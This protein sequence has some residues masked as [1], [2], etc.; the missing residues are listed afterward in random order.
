[1][2]AHTEPPP[3]ASPPM[4]AHRAAALEA[5]P[6]DPVAAPP[7]M[8]LTE[9]PTTLPESSWRSD[10]TTAQ[11]EHLGVPLVPYFLH[12][13]DPLPPPCRSWWK[14]LQ[15][16]NLK[17]PSAPKTD[18]EALRPSMPCV[19]H[20]TATAQPPSPRSGNR[21]A[22]LTDFPIGGAMAPT[23]AT[24]LHELDEVAVVEEQWQLELVDLQGS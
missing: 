23:S 12:A 9:P 20:A 22:Y 7:L 5:R 21:C 16:L 6:A 19:E 17:P 1:M 24:R 11:P 2:M 10:A 8:M 13:E 4:M 14:R 18:L 15:R 3:H